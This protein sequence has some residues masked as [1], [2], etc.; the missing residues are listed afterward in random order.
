MQFFSFFVV[1]RSAFNTKQ[2]SY[3]R[4]QLVIGFAEN[5][6]HEQRQRSR[7]NSLLPTA[8]QPIRSISMTTRL[9]N[10]L[11]PVE[12][13]LV[14][15]GIQRQSQ[16]TE[17]SRLQMS[18]LSDSIAPATVGMRQ[19]CDFLLIRLI[20]DHFIPPDVKTQRTQ[21]LLWRSL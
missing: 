13:I 19:L 8:R 1:D 14:L 16:H 2:A 21:L 9:E 12:K 3:R 11:R 15:A 17:A 18:T 5:L 7:P 6:Q 20:I 10:R 4:L